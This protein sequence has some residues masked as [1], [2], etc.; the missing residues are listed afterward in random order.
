MRYKRL[1][2]DNADGL[3]LNDRDERY[4]FDAL[5]AR[6]AR[7]NQQS[8][9]PSSSKRLPGGTIAQADDPGELEDLYDQES[10]KQ[11]LGAFLQ[12]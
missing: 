2:S 8:T 6:P 10:K 9:A 11:A 12:Q 3:G 5:S 1:I 7:G 4:T